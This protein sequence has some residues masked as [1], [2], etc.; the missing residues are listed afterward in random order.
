[1]ARALILGSG[2]IGRG[3]LPWVLKGFDI[4]FYDSN[5][6]LAH[7]INQQSGYNSF[8]SFPT[9]LKKKF[10]AT[11]GIK[12]SFSTKEKLEYDIAFS[13]VG[14]RNVMGL[15]RE[16][17]RLQCPLFSLENDPQ[18]VQALK[19]QFK[20]TDVFFGVP[21][22]IS[23]STA[24]PQNLEI[25]PFSIHTENG[26]LYL[27]KPTN[28]SKGLINKLELVKWLP[29]EQLNQEWDAK[30]YLHNTPHCIAAFLGHLL[31]KKYL[32]EALAVD[33][34][35]VVIHGVV[36]E[37]LQGLKY[38]TKYD[39]VF[40]ENYAKKEVR[41]FSNELLFDPINRV[42]RDPLRKLQPGGRLLGALRLLLSA[43]I[44]P[45]Y[46]MV[47]L[48]AALN[49]L[50]KGDS[51]YNQ[52]SHVKVFGLPAFLHYHLGLNSDSLESKYIQTKLPQA[53]AYI[54]REIL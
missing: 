15:P 53:M 23:S 50:N 6:D 27:H 43:G 40:M 11:N 33:A 29:L 2:A 16:L 35:R 48:A 31:N 4:E 8:M 25:D 14:P 47:G 32:H 34:I 18:T 10:V 30:L 12:T 39:H 20:L 54:D 1:M 17:A 46:L 26:V 19:Q 7:G 38:Y 28:I 45:T 51:D 22:V 5:V 3:F 21:D 42:A 49:Y 37:L 41:R 13:A 44:N 36:D 52:L 9:G 24:S